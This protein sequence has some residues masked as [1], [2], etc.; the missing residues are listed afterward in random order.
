M[1][2]GVGDGEGRAGRRVLRDGGPYPLIAS[3]ALQGRFLL[4]SLISFPSLA[5]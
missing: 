2:V 5:N 4:R 1:Q 3:L